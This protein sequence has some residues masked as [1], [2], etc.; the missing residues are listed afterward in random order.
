MGG[1]YAGELAIAHGRIEALNV[2]AKRT[3]EGQWL[4]G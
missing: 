3:K 2:A 4:N 1:E